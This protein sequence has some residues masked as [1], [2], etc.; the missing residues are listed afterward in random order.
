M[1][2]RHLTGHAVD[3]VA[4]HEG[5]YTYEPFELYVDIAEGFRRA[6]IELDVEV[7]WGASWLRPLNEYL[8]AQSAMDDYV[9]ARRAENRRPF[10]DG[11]HFQLTWRSH[12]E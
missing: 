11:P 7:M 2:S 5:V 1:R 4:H 10:M 9:K 12:P 6:A 8:S 3:V